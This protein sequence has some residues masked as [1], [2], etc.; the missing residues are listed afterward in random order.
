MCCTQNPCPGGRPLL[1]CTSAGD[2][3][4]LKGRPDSVSV[5]FPGVQNGLFEPS[6][7][8]WQVWGLI[9]YAILPLLS[10]CWGF[11]FALDV[12]YILMVWSNILL[13]MVV[14]QRVV[15]LEFL[16]EKMSTHPFTLTS[17]FSMVFGLQKVLIRE[18]N[19]S[20]FQR[21]DRWLNCTHIRTWITKEM[22]VMKSQPGGKWCWW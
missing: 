13:S 12:G 6:Q 5:G 20:S 4:T 19:M 21:R 1:N 7:R 14:Q 18:I 16:P 9:L 15:I 17:C 22:V 10:F 8:L 3:Q 11:S 2:T